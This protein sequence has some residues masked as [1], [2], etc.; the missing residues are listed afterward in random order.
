MRNAWYLKGVIPLTFSACLRKAWY[1]ERQALLTARIEERVLET[2]PRPY[3]LPGGMAFEAGCLDYY[4]NARN[5]H[6]F[7]D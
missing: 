1:N 6:Y 3:N 2:A 7:G 4:A 5:G